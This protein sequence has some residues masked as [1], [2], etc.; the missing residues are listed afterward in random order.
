MFAATATGSDSAARNILLA[1]RGYAAYLVGR[2][3]LSLGEKIGL[4][5]AKVL[6]L[7]IQIFAG[8]SRETQDHRHCTALGFPPLCG[9]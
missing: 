3:C 5:A 6:A 7:L 8:C 1:T 9:R 2:Y 4:A